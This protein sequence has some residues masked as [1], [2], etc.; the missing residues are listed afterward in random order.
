[1]KATTRREVLTAAAA[2]GIAGSATG[3][4]PKE[5]KPRSR[6]NNEPTVASKASADNHGPR[7][8]FADGKLKRGMHVVG[9]AA[10]EEGIY[11]VVFRRDVRR[12]VY[13]AT[14]GGHGYEGLPPVGIASVMGLSTNPRAVVV[15]TT[16]ALGDNVSLI[17]K[18]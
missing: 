2:L 3:Q 1:M 6:H 9:V 15:S 7:E 12:G 18:P 5:K 8:M 13:L 14:V 10:I 16:N 11:E 4:A 17:G